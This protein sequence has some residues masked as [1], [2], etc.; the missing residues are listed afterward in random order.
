MIDIELSD[1][2]SL[3]HLHVSGDHV[4]ITPVGQR[5]ALD[6]VVQFLKQHPDLML[7][8]LA[9]AEQG[10]AATLPPPHH[11]LL[12]SRIRAVLLEPGRARFRP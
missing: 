4:F 3:G 2:G 8:S 11:R 9:V 12:A 7:G 5:A 6:A 1:D 10:V